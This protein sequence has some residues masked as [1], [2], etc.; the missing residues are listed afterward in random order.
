MCAKKF[1]TRRTDNQP[2]LTT[3]WLSFVM[4][5]QLLHKLSDQ[6]H[7]AGGSARRAQQLQAAAKRALLHGVHSA[8]GEC[9]LEPLIW[10]HLIIHPFNQ[11]MAQSSHHSS[12]Y[13]VVHPSNNLTA[14]RAFQE[15]ERGQ[16]PALHNL[17]TSPLLSASSRAQLVGRTN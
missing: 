7:A 14:V 13:H 1:T 15:R 16:Q 11:H 12:P 5:L 3:V 2:H 6:G 17:S 10:R 4:H 9:R 8:A